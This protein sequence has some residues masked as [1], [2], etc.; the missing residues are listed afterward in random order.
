MVSVMKLGRVQVMVA[1]GTRDEGFQ[2][3]LKPLALFCPVVL[4]RH[5][6]L[7]LLLAFLLL[8]AITEMKVPINGCQT[9]SSASY[10]FQRRP[11]ALDSKP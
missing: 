9:G 5:H 3:P 4:A 6:G 10:W 11:G 2:T 7:R 1:Q 8:D